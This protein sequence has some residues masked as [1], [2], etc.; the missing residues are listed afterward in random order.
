MTEPTGHG[1]FVLRPGRLAGIAPE[2]QV[3]ADLV[4][5][6]RVEGAERSQS[7]TATTT[8]A[9]PPVGRQRRRPADRG[10][11]AE[12]G[13]SPP[14]DRSGCGGPPGPEPQGPPRR[15]PGSAALIIPGHETSGR[16]ACARPARLIGE[17]GFAGNARALA[18]AFFAHAPPPPA[19]RRRATAA[20]RAR[21]RGATRRRAAGAAAERQPGGAARRRRARNRAPQRRTSGSEDCACGPKPAA[22]ARQPPPPR[23]RG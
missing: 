19:P 9:K 4:R 14:R 22:E 12:S 6:H 18:A 11:P 23:R 1:Q 2:Y 3:E 15:A 8:K 16:G 21:R 13:G 5:L 17:R 10:S 7:S 20:L